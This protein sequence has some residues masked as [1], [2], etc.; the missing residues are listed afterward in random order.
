MHFQTNH[1]LDLPQTWWVYP[2]FCAPGLINLIYFMSFHISLGPDQRKH[3]SSSSL[4]FVRGIHRWQVNSPHKGPVT[5]KMFPFDDFIMDYQILIAS[6]HSLQCFDTDWGPVWLDQ[7]WNRFQNPVRLFRPDFPKPNPDS[8]N[9]ET[10]PGAGFFGFKMA[11]GD[12][13]VSVE[14]SDNLFWQSTV[15]NFTIKS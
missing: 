8:W 10:S 14:T 3:Q 4:A 5:Q 12:G 13:Q 9:H 7:N 11:D 2:L 6:S 1:L 15:H